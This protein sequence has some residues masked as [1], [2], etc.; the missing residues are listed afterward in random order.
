MH[1]QEINTVK[2]EMVEQITTKELIFRIN[3]MRH[4]IM[5][6]AHKS[7][8]SNLYYEIIMGF[9]AFYKIYRS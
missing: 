6:P 5:E 8:E 1:I 7:P 3:Q 9:I 2:K 4:L